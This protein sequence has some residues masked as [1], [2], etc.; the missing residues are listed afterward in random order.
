MRDIDKSKYTVATG[1][2]LVVFDTSVMPALSEAS[3]MTMVRQYMDERAIWVASGSPLRTDERIAELFKICQACPKIESTLGQSF[4]GICHCRVANSGTKLNKLA[5]ATT[6]C[7]DDPPRWKNDVRV[8]DEV[9]AALQ[10]EAA[11]PCGGCGGEK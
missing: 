6:V 5:W 1:G 10:E 11:K 3:S 2:T 7:P 9:L 8:S 4:C